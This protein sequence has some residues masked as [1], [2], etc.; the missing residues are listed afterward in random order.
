VTQTHDSD[1][2]RTQGDVENDEKRARDA[3]VIAR[4]L[5][6]N[7]ESLRALVEALADREGDVKGLAS[8]TAALDV[9][10]GTL[11]DLVRLVEASRLVTVRAEWTG[12][13]EHVTAA[14]PAWF[15]RNISTAGFAGWAA[16]VVAAMFVIY[17]I[18]AG[19]LAGAA[20]AAG[21]VAA[22]IG[23]PVLAAYAAAILVVRRREQR[24][25]SPT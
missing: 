14:Q 3:L 11:V 10:R 2:P 5:S 9:Q 20:L 25:S 13:R 15:E 7:A 17:G 21:A 6:Q 19:S 24:E 4:Q 22:A 18:G 1:A 12:A 23:L 16:L 8:L